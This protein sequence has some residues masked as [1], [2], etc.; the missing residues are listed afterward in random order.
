MASE[1]AIVL[2]TYNGATFVGEQVA[3]LLAQTTPPAELVVADDRSTDDTLRI[4]EDALVSVPFPVRL[5]RNQERKGYRRNFIEASSL[6]TAPLVAFCDQDDVWR[7]D[8]LARM[9][10]AFA[11]PAVLLAYH[12]AAIVDRHG[13]FAGRLYGPDGGRKRS[14]SSLADPWSFSLGF[15]QVFRRELTGFTPLQAASADFLFRGERL[16][17]DQW[18]FFLASSFGQVAFVD[19]DLVAYR[20]HDAN[21][22]S[23]VDRG[24]ARRLEILKATLDHSRGQ[25][26]DRRASLVAKAR[27]FRAIQVDTAQPQDR[28][29]KAAELAAHH[30]DMA[31]LYAARIGSYDRPMAEKGW[32]W[33]RLMTARGRLRARGL[34]YPLRHAARDLAFGVLF[35]HLAAPPART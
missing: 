21:V 22:F 10:Q 33:L 9:Q 17:H 30:E 31:D 32:A 2:A 4:I 34:A 23:A 14:D 15:T 19:E 6:C 26:E 35:G 1:T 3:S 12:N 8:K 25:I 20:Q 29:T 27:I 28:R 18:F 24:R 5:H 11:D 7:P 16:A 13:G